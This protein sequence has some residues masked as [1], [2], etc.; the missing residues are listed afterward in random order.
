MARAEAGSRKGAASPVPLVISPLGD[1]QAPFEAHWAASTLSSGW[2]RLGETGVLADLALP[3]LGTSPRLTSLSPP[4]QRSNKELSELIEQRQKN[5]YLRVRE[6][7]D[8]EAKMQS[9]SARL[10][11]G[12][13]R[14]QP[15]GTQGLDD[16]Q[17]LTW[18]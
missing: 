17:V 18:A 16:P 14:C 12:A 9:V 5:A 2:G 7:Q 10:P 8:T 1:S 3:L 15:L 13:P 11:P 4:V 6:H